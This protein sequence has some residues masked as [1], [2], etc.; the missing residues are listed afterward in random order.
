MTLTEGH[1]AILGS[2][3]WTQNGQH[4]LANCWSPNATTLGRTRG[5]VQ[6]QPTPRPARQPAF[7]DSANKRGNGDTSRQI[8]IHPYIHTCMHTYSDRDAFRVPKDKA[9]GRQHDKSY[10]LQR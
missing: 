6:R 1:R 9:A 5:G 8:Y 3:W 4:G 2:V 10:S 7:E